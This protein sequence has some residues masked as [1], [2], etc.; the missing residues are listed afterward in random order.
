MKVA[1]LS[2]IHGN[3]P[4]LQQ[5]ASHIEQWRADQVI[6]NGDIINRGPLSAA[7]WEFVQAQGWAIVGG[8][9]EAY[10]ANWLN[11][12][13]VRTGPEFEINQSSFWTFQRLNGVVDLLPQLP[14]RLSLV[15]PDQ[16]EVRLTHGSMLGNRDGI[17]P[18]TTD[19]E[20][21]RKIEPPPAVFI[22]GHTHKPLIRYLGETLVLNV[23]SAG[24]AFDG[25]VRASYGQLVWHSGRWSAAI[26]RLEYD[27]QQTDD[28][29]HQSGFFEGG[30]LA[31]LMYVEWRNAVNNISGWL[32]RYEAHVLA[33]EITLADSVARYRAEIG[34]EIGKL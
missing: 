7:C 33:G 21:Q 31:Y 30:P 6:V 15:G 24:Y 16:G 32:Q 8:N 18:F 20:L 10:V 17:Y 26:V 14:P 2:D 22:T 25:D 34:L 3:L 5:V 4:A 13:T 28:D 23:G 1:V 19:D 27:R 12:Q 9:H 11:P 29:F